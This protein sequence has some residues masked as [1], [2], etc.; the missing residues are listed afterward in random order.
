M[1][2]PPLA[3]D[4]EKSFARVSFRC[5]LRESV[6]ALRLGENSVATLVFYITRTKVPNVEYTSMAVTAKNSRCDVE[7]PR[8]ARYA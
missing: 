6:A 4:M 7:W 2:K 3:L 8:A 1:R 5:S